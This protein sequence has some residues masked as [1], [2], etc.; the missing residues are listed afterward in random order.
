MSKCSDPQKVVSAAAYLL[1]YRRRSETPLGGPKFQEIFDKYDSQ[2]ASADQDMSDSG[3]GQRLGLS[4]SLR[5]SPSASTGAGLTLP[6]GKRGLVSDDSD[7]AGQALVPADPELPSYQASVGNGDEDT[8]MGAALWDQSTLHNSIEG[9]EDEGIGLPDYD[10][11]GMAG[12]TSV[13]GSNWNFQN[14]KPGSVASDGD[15]ASDIAQNDNSSND[16]GFAAGDEMDEVF[17]SGPS[18]E[19]IEHE[20]T[21]PEEEIPAPPAEAQNLFDQI[22]EDKWAQQQIH[23]VPADIADDHASDKVAEIRVGDGGEDQQAQVQKP[24]A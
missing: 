18:L 24:S 9:D 10:N 6:R 5:G 19:F 16:D 7:R 15:I 8:E 11:G 14:I 13:I 3:E 21:F 20:P 17:M 1:F 12:M 4:S 22:A 2:I 23:T